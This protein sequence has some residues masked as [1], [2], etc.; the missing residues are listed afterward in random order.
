[1]S[2]ETS[3]RPD[4]GI[5]IPDAAP[6][7][8][9][10]GIRAERAFAANVLGTLTLTISDRVGAA[11]TRVTRHGANA[12]AALVSLL[13]YPDRPI[14]FLAARL[15]ISHPGAVQLVD[16]LETDGLL[17]RIPALDGR[18]KL[19]A[20]TTLGE[21]TALGV[22]AQRREILD[23]AVSSL[24][25]DT[26]RALSGAVSAMLEALTDDLLT[27]EHMCRMCDE[28]ACPDAR[29]PVERAEPAPRHRRGAGYGVSEPHED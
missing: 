29:C 24:D 20:L 9:R 5:A 21:K 28:L 1:M 3:L 17:E 16:R 8:P 15:R 23:R 6:R 14:A 25:D 2:R 13:W 11:A 7:P 19:V 22:L 10:R 18:T 4:A 12:P 26:V 27:S